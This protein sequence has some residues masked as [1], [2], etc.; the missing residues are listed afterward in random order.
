MHLHSQNDAPRCA[1]PI[2]AVSDD[3]YYTPVAKPRPSPTLFYFPGLTSTPWHDTNNLKWVQRLEANRDVITNEFLTL[4]KKRHGLAK[5]SNDYKVYDKEHQ[6]HQGH[7]D[8]LSYVTQGRRQAD[9]VLQCP[10]TVEILESIPDFMAESP[11][12]YSF[13]SILKPKVVL[14]STYFDVN[15]ETDHNFWGF[16]SSI[17][18][19]S[20]PCNIRLRCHF[21]LIVPEGC[22]IRVGDETRHWEEG[23]AFVFD[24]SF[25]HEVWHDGK[26]GDRVLLLFDLWHPDLVLKERNAVTEM[27]NDAKEKGWLK[28]Y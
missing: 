16:L 23:K 21:P 3:G 15:W 4:Q 22:G 26:E 9:F 25:D 28:D 20:A 12:A 13:F 10:K 11:F 2:G 1:T 14:L 24:D 19:H 8:W 7:W 6:L 5:N 17:K 27:F 18:A